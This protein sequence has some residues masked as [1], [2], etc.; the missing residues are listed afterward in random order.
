[1]RGVK[2]GEERR[3]AAVLLDTMSIAFANVGFLVQGE[4]SRG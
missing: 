4:F 1:M 2:E 3:R